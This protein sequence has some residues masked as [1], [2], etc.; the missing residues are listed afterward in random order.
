MSGLG[1]AC[2]IAGAALLAGCTGNLVSAPVRV[3]ANKV[4]PA[5][6]GELYDGSYQ[7]SA[8]LVRALGPACPRRP[9]YGVVEIG[10][11]VLV[12][13]YTPELTFSVPVLRDGTMRLEGDGISLRGRIVGN[14]L[15]FVVRTPKC[16][17]LYRMHYVW[18]H[19]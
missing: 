12:L 19:S 4:V 1:R 5:T 11:A 14:Q 8:T 7:G 15:G 17:T 13:P 6:P 2:A 16:E 3:G 10:D 18:N 9:S